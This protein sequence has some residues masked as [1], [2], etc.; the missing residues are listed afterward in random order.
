MR[1]ITLP[2]FPSQL[3]INNNTCT[4]INGTGNGTL[5][6][7]S[8]CS[9]KVT[10]DQTPP[11]GVFSDSIS[12]NDGISSETQKSNFSIEFK[13]AI[14]ANV[15][16]ESA[17]LN[18]I[19]SAG[20]GDAYN[21][22][23]VESNTYSRLTLKYINIG[24]GDA[25]S[26]TVDA[27][28]PIPSGYVES[29]TASTCNNFTLESNSGNSCVIVFDVPTSQTG[30]ASLILNNS[31]LPVTW[32]D[33]SGMQ[34]SKSINWINSAT[35]PSTSQETV[36]LNIYNKTIV[37]AV[38]SSESSGVISIESVTSYTNFYLHYDM[39]GGYLEESYTYSPVI[40]YG[41]S[42]VNESYCN[43]S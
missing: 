36:F 17:T 7:G 28:H 4:S 39:N 34:E 14:A 43:L 38:L 24:N 15:I 3:S 25:E 27:S 16:I 31:S 22:Y 12:Y 29:A 37:N 11:S 13:G 20:I 42:F 9:F 23:Q 8:S 18:P 35:T 26:F 1:D 30:D 2:T 33:E 40:P 6:V 19:Q 21:P 10:Y 41:M 5:N 32:V